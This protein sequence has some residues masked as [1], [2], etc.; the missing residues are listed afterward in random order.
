MSE[1][2]DPNQPAVYYSGL[3]DA[4]GNLVGE[5]EMGEWRASWLPDPLPTIKVPL[6]ELGLP[7]GALPWEDEPE[8]D[9]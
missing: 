8:E 5:I 7:K 6:E 2:P 3:Y 4:E 1:L 9:E